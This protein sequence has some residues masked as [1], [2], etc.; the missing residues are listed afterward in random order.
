MPVAPLIARKRFNGRRISRLTAL[1]IPFRGLSASTD[2]TFRPAGAS[3]GC[4][5]PSVCRNVPEV[6]RK[7]PSA[8]GRQPG[9][10]LKPFT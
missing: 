1:R 8:P 3:S 5:L 4:Q 7:T 2:A 10:G 6:R 9:M